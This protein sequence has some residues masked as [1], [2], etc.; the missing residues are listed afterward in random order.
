MQENR[1][2]KIR[3][4]VSEVS[5]FVGNPVSNSLICAILLDTLICVN[6]SNYA[7]NV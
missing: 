1:L 5:S 2:K 3:T 6:L 7:V 4:I